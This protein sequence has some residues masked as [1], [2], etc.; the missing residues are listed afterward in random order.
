MLLRLSEI[1]IISETSFSFTFPMFLRFQ[2]YSLRILILDI[3]LFMA[4]FNPN[5]SYIETAKIDTSARR[6]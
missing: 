5:T 3:N 4:S 2:F 6:L 1:L